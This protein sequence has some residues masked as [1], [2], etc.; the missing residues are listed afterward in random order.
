MPPKKMTSLAMISVRSR[1]TGVEIGPAARL[2]PAGDMY[3]AAF[4]Q[5][6]AALDRQL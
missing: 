2:E 1:T 4:V 3:A 5:V 6:V